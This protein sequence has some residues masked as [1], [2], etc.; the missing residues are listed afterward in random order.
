MPAEQELATKDITILELDHPGAKDPAYRARRNDLAALAVHHRRNGLDAPTIQYTEEEND[1]W[2]IVT[3]WLNP[4]HEKH[5]CRIHVD[6]RHRLE[7]PD[8]YIPQLNALS[9][10][11]ERFHGFRLRAIE[12]LIEPKVFLSGLGDHIMLCTQ[13]I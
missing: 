2:R 1:T 12:G 3:D 7:I 10:R 13:Y 6:A 11:L 4:L 8:D 5:A 9:D